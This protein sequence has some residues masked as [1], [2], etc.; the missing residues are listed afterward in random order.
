MKRRYTML[1]VF[2]GFC[3]PLLAEAAQAVPAQ[4]LSIA[5][6][7]FVK[8]DTGARGSVTLTN[9]G[10]K[11]IAAYVL[12]I[13][14]GDSSGKPLWS[15]VRAGLTN[16]VIPSTPRGP[17]NPGERLKMEIDIPV[18][19]AV[20]K[21]RVDVQLDYVLF[22]DDSSWGPDRSQESLVVKGMR[23]GAIA[24]RAGLRQVL[25]RKG[26]DALADELSR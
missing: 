15:G 17:Y 6:E 11:D 10:S 22:T 19:L 26:K 13:V 21:E 25:Q 3:A 18:T 7:P 1:L 14:V 8:T 20:S 4:P 9:A 12:R 2:L 24:E 5:S 23:R 16:A